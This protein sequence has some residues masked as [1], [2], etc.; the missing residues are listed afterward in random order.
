MPGQAGQAGTGLVASSPGDFFP[1]L[2]LRGL[3][4][5]HHRIDEYWAEQSCEQGLNPLEK[6]EYVAF[7][8]AYQPVTTDFFPNR[9]GAESLPHPG[10]PGF[11]CQAIF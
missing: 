4:A 8:G 6:I 3:P 2:L 7:I 11:R 1:D 10:N 5:L 9:F